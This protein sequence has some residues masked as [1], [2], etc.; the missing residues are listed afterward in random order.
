MNDLNGRVIEGQV[1]RFTDPL[2]PQDDPQRLLDALDAALN[3]P[4]VEAVMWTQ[5]TPSWNDGDACVFGVRGASVKIAGDEEDLSDTDEYDDSETQGFR[6]TYSLYD[7]GPG[8]YTDK[9]F[10]VI[11][12]TDCGL[13]Y[14][15]LI[16]LERTLESGRHDAVLSEKFGD[17]AAVIATKD[18]F[19]IEDYEAPY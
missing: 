14:D 6:D 1:N 19:K 4:G 9:K 12:E 18:G 3:I 15:A 2:P 5:Y 16:E 8:G 17:P 13:V 7:Y 10:H 11:G